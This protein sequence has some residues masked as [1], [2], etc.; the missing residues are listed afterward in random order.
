MQ[1]DAI[2]TS[3]ETGPA[4]GEFTLRRP[5]ASL[6][7]T[8][9]DVLFSPR[10]YFDW[11]PPDGPAGSPTLY[12]LICYLITS[13]IN[14]LATVPFLALPMI[15]ATTANPS[16]AWPFAL[17]TLAFLFVFLVMYPVFVAGSFFVG[18]AVQHAFIFLVAGRNQRGLRATLR[19]SCYS[20]GAAVVVAWIPI[21]GLVAALY[22]FYLYVTGLRRVHGISAVRAL[23]AVIIP[24]ALS[25]ALMAVGIFFGYKALREAFD[26]PNSYTSYYFPEPEAS[27]DLPPGVVGAV[28]LTDESRDQ[29]KVRNLRENSYADT[30]PGAESGAMVYFV[31]ADPKDGPRG[32]E[33]SVSDG[34]GETLR[35][36]SEPARG[37][38]GTDD[39][40]YYASES[41]ER[42]PKNYYEERVV[43]PALAQQFALSGGGDYVIEVD[44]IG[45]EPRIIRVQTYDAND[46]PDG[47]AYFYVPYRTTEPGTR[48]RLRISPGE[49]LDDLR[50]QM[51]HDA[52]GTYEES[53][54]PEATVVGPAAGDG[55]DPVTIAHLREPSDGNGPFLDLKAT[56]QPAS[57]DEAPSSGVGVIYYWIND[58]GPRIYTEPLSVESGDVITYWSIDRASNIEW[59][60]TTDIGSRPPKIQASKPVAASGSS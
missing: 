14:A 3:G 49:Q 40:S 48:L 10:R 29:G 2:N 9:R 20:V 5:F 30:A 27:E 57:G 28:A 35:I 32:V 6:I 17:F 51:D 52:D 50:L 45:E 38:D 43:Q 23:I 53:W 21:A 36:E 34:E 60:R 37:R 54:M 39:L 18:V 11:L 42:S 12:F 47:K 15:F 46:T 33:G 41:V 44:Q 1:E 19:V 59:R 24:T 26:E 25:L 31:T 55:T 13:L 8:T 56:D 22:V 4:F 16:E 58:S 7:S